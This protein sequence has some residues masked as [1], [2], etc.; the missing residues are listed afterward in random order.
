MHSDG[1]QDL[2]RHKNAFM[3]LCMR[4]TVDLPD[5]LLIAAKKLAAELRRPLR[6]LIEEC[7]RQRLAAGHNLAPPTEINWVVVEGG[8][9]EGLDLSDREAMSDLML[10]RDI[11]RR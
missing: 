10:R 6:D 11:D 2:T 7:L 8:L 9:P 4:T 1:H 3:L 5:E